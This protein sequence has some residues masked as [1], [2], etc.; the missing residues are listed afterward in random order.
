MGLRFDIT[1]RIIQ[2]SCDRE[3]TS[4][5]VIIPALQR[6]GV[7]SQGGNAAHL[8]IG[9][10]Y[11]FMACSGSKGLGR[12]YPLLGIRHVFAGKVWLQPLSLVNGLTDI[13][14]IV[15]DE[16]ETVA[17]RIMMRYKTIGKWC[18]KAFVQCM[19]RLFLRH[20]TWITLCSAT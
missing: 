13:P 2:E 18:C 5:K 16:N 6:K 9:E 3:E 14:Y 17:V 4:V 1:R 7:R 11:L 19:A 10:C 12:G 20:W 8:K 15:M